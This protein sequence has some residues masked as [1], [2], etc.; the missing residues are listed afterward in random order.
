MD[1]S[2]TPPSPPFSGR[3]TR[4]R[5]RAT[6]ATP[7][8]PVNTTPSPDKGRAGEGLTP[9]AAS[10]A[11]NPQATPAPKHLLYNPKLTALARA[12]RQNPTP[13]ETILWQKVLRSRQFSG[14]KFLRQKPIGPYIVDF[15]CAALKLVIE[16]DGDS[17]AAQA[18]YDAKR[19][20]FLLQHGLHVQRY[21]N[22]DVC[23][24]LAGIH[25]DLTSHI[26]KS[27]V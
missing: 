8:E 1:K 21:S 13:A 15:Y 24:Q 27:P 12:N 25:D 18:S 11:R 5:S 22:L 7:I 4:T 23:Q 6:E 19:S 16:V 17:H 14:H 9:V 10:S 2:L 20:D 3:E 26:K